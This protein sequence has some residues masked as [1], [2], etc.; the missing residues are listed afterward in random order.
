MSKYKAISQKRIV[1]AHSIVLFCFQVLAAGDT[2]EIAIQALRQEIRSLNQS[3]IAIRSELNDIKRLL[4]EDLARSRPGLPAPSQRP[5]ATSLLRM[6]SAPAMGSGNAKL[7]MVE[8]SDFE[9]DFCANYAGQ[10]FPQI[11]RDYI[12]PGK[13][14]YVSMNFSLPMHPNAPQAAQASLCAG[15][16]GKYWEMHR[17]L[18]ATQGNVSATNLLIF[19]AALG[20]DTN[21]F[22]Q[23]LLSRKFDA[24]LKQNVAEGH[25]AGVAGTPTFL[26]GLTEADGTFIRPLKT[27]NGQKPYAAFKQTIDSL[28]QSPA[29]TVLTQQVFLDITNAPFKGNEEAKLT[30]V[31]FTD[32]QCPFC[33][34]YAHETLP[35]ILRD[36]VDSGKV[37]YVMLNFPLQVHHDA[38]QAAQ[39][40]LCAGEQGRFWDMHDR[41]F[42]DQQALNTNAFLADAKAIGL[43]VAQFQTSLLSGKYGSTI[44]ANAKQGLQAG[45]LGTPTFFIGHTTDDGRFQADRMM[46]GSRAYWNFKET[47]EGLLAATN[48]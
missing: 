43:D 33:G 47:I 44:L 41:L 11:Q 1:V 25:S 5:Q 45:V 31:E 2:N 17:L 21:A 18:F 20:L 26:F 48:K 30:V 24:Q 9:C 13:I 12:D 16:Q 4:Q 46:K 15:D 8:F 37:K 3:Q 32:Y 38:P 23:C 36:Y 27:L 10:V 29:S 42:A 35:G 40:A 22:Q 19:A 6:G 34:H 39:A 28:L 14:K 7:T